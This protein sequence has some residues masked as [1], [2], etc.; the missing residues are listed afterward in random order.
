MPDS[1]LALAR[2]WRYG[3]SVQPFIRFVGVVN[4]A[5]WFGAAVFFTVVAGPAFFSAEMLSFLPKPYAGRA[6]EVIIERYLLLQQWC[7]AIALLHILVEYLYSGRQVDRWSLGLL[8]AMFVLALI[9]SFSL[10]PHMHELQRIMYATTT[11][12]AQQAA[13]KS[14]FG[15]LHG[16]AYLVNLL[17]ICGLVHYLWKVTRSVQPLRFGSSDKFRS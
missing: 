2:A 10:Q 15:L 17:M 14:R 5:V 16:A 1:S 4:I 7:G 8:S 13:A 3:A 12:V 11:S 6:A 9:G